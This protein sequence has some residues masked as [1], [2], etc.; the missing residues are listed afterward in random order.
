MNSS[1]STFGVRPPSLSL[2][3]SCAALDFAAAKEWCRSRQLQPDLLNPNLDH[4]ALRWMGAERL[5][6]ICVPWLD[7]RLT[8][9]DRPHLHILD[10]DGAPLGNLVYR[11]TSGER[12]GPDLQEI[13]FAADKLIGGCYQA[14]NRLCTPIFEEINRGT[15]P[16]RFAVRLSFG[17]VDY[18]CWRFT[19]EHLAREFLQRTADA[20]NKNGIVKDCSSDAVVLKRQLGCRVIVATFKVDSPVRNTPKPLARILQFPGKF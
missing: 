14:L 19:S 1:L 4:F 9:R 2:F 12:S 18:R 20:A 15:G 8:A 6:E 11:V 13:L 16:K 7:S 3:P 17:G 5:P 10:K